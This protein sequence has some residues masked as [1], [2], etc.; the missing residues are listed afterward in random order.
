MPVAKYERL[1]NYVMGFIYSPLLFITAY[2]ETKQAQVIQ[3]NRRA[4]EQD[5]D[6]VEEWEQMHSD[7]DFEGEG[8]AKKVDMTKPNVK[9]DATILEIQELKAQV[10]E[11]TKMMDGIE[12]LKSKTNGN[13]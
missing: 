8:W 11:I 13:S 7:I 9:T 5:E 10:L 2:V 4:G 1:N 12:G 3:T 6:T